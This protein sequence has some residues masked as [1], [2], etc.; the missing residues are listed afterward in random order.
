MTDIIQPNASADARCPHFEAVDETTLR[1]LFS[2]VAAARSEDY[3]LFQFTHRSMEVYRGTSAGGEIWT[4]DR[5]HREFSESRVNNFA[6]VIEGE[7]G[8][9]KSELCAYLS[10]KL[11]QEGRPM[12]HIDKD[13]DLMSILSERIPEFYEEQFGEMLP[14]ASDF[15]N[16]HDDASGGI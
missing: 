6:V 11:R 8:T 5:I 1:R 3:D 7:V 15:K 9:G 13:D 12:L 16:L 10:H 4:E 2:K 14:G